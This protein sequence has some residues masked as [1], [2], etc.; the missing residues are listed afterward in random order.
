LTA[1]QLKA[2]DYDKAG[3][4][5]FWSG[6]FDIPVRFENDRLDLEP[7]A[8]DFNGGAFKYIITTDITLTEIRL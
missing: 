5:V 2:L 3:A 6:E 8:P 4:D 1:K 7:Q